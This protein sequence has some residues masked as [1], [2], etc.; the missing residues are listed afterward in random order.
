MK[1]LNVTM[2]FADRSVYDRL[3]QLARSWGLPLG[4][5]IGKLVDKDLKKNDISW[6]Q[7]DNKKK[8]AI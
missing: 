8:V 4:I 6:G 2:H 3:K 7:K 1:R 5:V